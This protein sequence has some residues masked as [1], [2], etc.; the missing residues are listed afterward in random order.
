[1]TSNSVIIIGAGLG[2]LSCAIQCCRWGLKT[3]VLERAPE[4]REVSI[5][6]AHFVASALLIVRLRMRQIGAGIQIPPNAGRVLLEYG[7]FEDIRKRATQIDSFA[8]R[9]YSDGTALAERPLGH[10][11]ITAV[12]VPWL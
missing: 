3:L 12:G 7:I 4:I 9:R 5:S 6:L 8:L 10:K 2:G 1:M 11:F